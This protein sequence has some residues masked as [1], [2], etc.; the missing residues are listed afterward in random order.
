MILGRILGVAFSV[1]LGSAFA[2]R[3]N[4]VR[5]RLFGVLPQSRKILDRYYPLD[6][7]IN[8]RITGAVDKIRN[9]NVDP[10]ETTRSRYG[11][12][13]PGEAK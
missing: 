8:R 11:E 12:G 13:L 7:G 1:L 3:F 2:L 5:E 9:K 6:M 10:F 4:P